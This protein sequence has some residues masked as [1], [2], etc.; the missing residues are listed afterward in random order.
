MAD[1]SNLP[2]TGPAGNPNDEA[3]LSNI[4]S[5]ISDLQ[6]QM[7]ETY[8]KLNEEMSFGE[9]TDK[10]VKVTASATYQFHDIIFGEQAFEGGVVAF[11]TR[12]LEALNNLTKTIQRT[13]QEKTMELLQGMNIP[14]EIK[15]LSLGQDKAESED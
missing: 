6:S 14:D 9:S 8:A 2:T 5:S 15:N 11:K 10:T 7:Q 3:L 1:Q 4:R 13:T 12:C